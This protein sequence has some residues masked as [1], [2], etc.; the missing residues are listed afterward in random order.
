MITGPCDV[1][2]ELGEGSESLDQ[3]KRTITEIEISFCNIDP[4]KALDIVCELRGVQAKSVSGQVLTAASRLSSRQNLLSC[5][6]L[7]FNPDDSFQEF[8]SVQ[9]ALGDV[10]LRLAGHLHV[11]VSRAPD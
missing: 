3:A 6:R 4:N 5:W 2:E 7:L 9:R 1:T 8:R 10:G 11:S